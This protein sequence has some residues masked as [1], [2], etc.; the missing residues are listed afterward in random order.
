MYFYNILHFSDY[1]LQTD[2]YDEN[3]VHE[4]IVV[5]GNILMFKKCEI[6]SL[7]VKMYTIQ[8]KNKK[9]SKLGDSSCANS[10]SSIKNSLHGGS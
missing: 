2:V 4:Q 10:F 5:F 6:G 3:N 9:E 7:A 8:Y 1:Q